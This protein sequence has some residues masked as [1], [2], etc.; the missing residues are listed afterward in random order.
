MVLL[1]S[2]RKN[3]AIRFPDSVS[4]EDPFLSLETSSI[5]LR[6]MQKT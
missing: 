3:G 6:K 5:I 2:I 1:D 4:P